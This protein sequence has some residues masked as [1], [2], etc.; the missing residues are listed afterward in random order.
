[1]QGR[2]VSRSREKLNLTACSRAG[3][4]VADPVSIRGSSVSLDDT[5]LTRYHNTGYGG[6]YSYPTPQSSHG[7]GKELAA[8]AL[9]AMGGAALGECPRQSV[10]QLKVTLF[11]HLNLIRCLNLI[12]R[13]STP[14]HASLLSA[15]LAYVGSSCC[16]T[17]LVNPSWAIV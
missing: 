3:L 8:A 16:S 10:S 11:S 2:V 1:M 14:C 6:A 15:E 13:V 9:G 12:V 17:F 4:H 7:L 5:P